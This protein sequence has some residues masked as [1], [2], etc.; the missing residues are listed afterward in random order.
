MSKMAII[1][2]HKQHARIGITQS[3]GVGIITIGV[4][5]V[6]AP[7]INVVKRGI[8]I[9]SETKLGSGLGGVSTIRNLS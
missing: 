4:E 7:N 2:T 5:T 1:E 9:I 8:L 3:L 6:V